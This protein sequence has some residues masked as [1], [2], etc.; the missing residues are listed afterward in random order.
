MSVTLVE[1]LGPNSHMVSF[2]P[3]Q[4][5]L[6]LKLEDKLNRH[7]SCDLLPS[8]SRPFTFSASCR[9]MGG[10]DRIAAVA[11]NSENSGPSLFPPQQVIIFRSWQLNWSSW[12]SSAR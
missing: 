7:L 5:T 1:K 9:A 8:K 6:L 11:I 12:D 10:G 3:C 2:S 4:L